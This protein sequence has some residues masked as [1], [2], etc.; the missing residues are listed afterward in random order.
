MGES[1]AP[2]GVGSPVGV[3]SEELLPLVRWNRRNCAPCGGGIAETA[4]PVEVGLEKLR[5]LWEWDRRNCGLPGDGIGETA[6]PKR[7]GSE[8][9]RPLWGAL[10]P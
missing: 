3:G 2:G 9:L 6:A 10:P 8:K 7:V 4:V 1:A 5:H